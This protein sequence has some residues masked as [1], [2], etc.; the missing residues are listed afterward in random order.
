VT[1]IPFAAGEFIEFR[2]PNAAGY[3]DPL[4]RDPAAVREDVLDDFTTVELARDAY[5]VVFADER[6]LELDVAATEARRDEL[7]GRRDGG[8]LS[9][10]FAGRPLPASSS[11]VSVAG[12]EEFAVR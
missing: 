4:D 3:G 2:E 6:T 12:N 1:G 11:P 7:R 9:E 8:S 5:G 10:H